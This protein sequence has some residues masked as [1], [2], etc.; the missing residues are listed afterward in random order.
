MGWRLYAVGKAYSGSPT[1]R[2][3]IT[4]RSSYSICPERA[5]RPPCS[6]VR[7][8]FALPVDLPSYSIFVVFRS[9]AF[10]LRW[11]WPVYVP[12]VSTCRCDNPTVRRSKS[13]C[14]PSI[15]SHQCVDCTTIAYASECGDRLVSCVE[16]TVYKFLKLFFYSPVYLY[17]NYP[18]P[19][20][21]VH[22]DQ[23][24]K[25]I[26]WGWQIYG[27]AD[28]RSKYVVSIMT[29]MYHVHHMYRPCSDI[30]CAW[31]SCHHMKQELSFKNTFG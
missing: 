17:P 7:V 10:P 28:G 31:V 20:A 11:L 30:F 21:T 18:G 23:N 13:L 25:L 15:L 29:C 27:F 22:A 12:F 4:R 8:Y 6:S 2:F 14:A 9:F 3:F 1:P 16:N 5:I 19:L 26:R 24:S